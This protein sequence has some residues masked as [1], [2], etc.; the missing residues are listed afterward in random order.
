MITEDIIRVLFRD[1]QATAAIE[2]WLECRKGKRIEP[3]CIRFNRELAQTALINR[4][5][6]YSVDDAEYAFKYAQKVRLEPDM[7]GLKDFGVFGLLAH[8]PRD[9]LTTDVHNDCLC[10]SDQLLN[11]RKLAHPIGPIIFVAAFLAH[12]DIVHPFNRKTFSQSPIVRSDN[13]DLQIVLNRGMAENHFHIGGSTDASI[14]QWICLM[15]HISGNRRAEFLKMK[16]KTQPLDSHPADESLFP[17]VVKAAFIR[18][19]LYCKLQGMVAFMPDVTWDDSQIARYMK[20]PVDKLQGMSVFERN[21][22]WDNCQITWF[23]DMPF[24][25]CELYTRDLD[26]YTYSLRALCPKEEDAN[27]FVSDYALYGEPAPPL[28]DSDLFHIRGRAVRNYE[29]RLYFPIAGEQR[30]LYY[31]FQAIYKKDPAITPYLDLAY[32]YVLIYCKFRA[33]LVQVNERV[34]FKNFLQYQDRKEYFTENHGEYD[35]LRCEIA[36][37]VVTVN[38][39]TAAFEGRMIPS[40]TAE[41]LREKVRRMLTFAAQTE[42]SSPYVQSLLAPHS[43]DFSES[44]NNLEYEKLILLQNRFNIPA[45][46]ELTLNTLKS[47][48]KKLS[49]VLHFAKIAQPILDADDCSPGVAELF[50]LT[51]PRDSQLRQRVKQQSDAIISA[52]AKYPH[53]M[54][55]ITGIDACSSEIDCRPEVFAPQFRRMIQDVPPQK[56]AYEDEYTIP[57][58]RI[59]YHVGEDFLDP[60]DGLRAIDE[61]IEYLDMKPGDRIGHALALGVDCDEWYAFK[62]NTVLLQKQA[63]L[64]NLVWLYGTMLKYNI[65]DTEVETHV[66]KWFK[67]LYKQIFAD[68]L[69]FNKNNHVSILSNIDIEDY[70][71][72]MALRG[73]DPWVYVHNPDGD[74]EERDG[75]ME[76]LR[77]AENEP[78]KLRIKA[79]K[80]YDT[81][82]NTLYHCYHWNYSVKLES[83]RIEEYEVPQCIVR[84]VSLVQKRMRFEIAQ[85]G[86]GIECNPSSNYLIGTFRDYM[87]HPIFKFDNQYLYATSNSA[88]QVPNPH[89]KASINTDDLGIFDTSLE[90]EYALMASALHNHNSHC[91]PEDRI[92]PQQIYAWLDHIRQNGCEQ[93]FKLM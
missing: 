50:E 23:M 31:L 51:H 39:Q 48:N 76:D 64:D 33:E 63:L 47:T 61:A 49:Y 53:V 74:Y 62:G 92:S 29:R 13:D 6:H 81:V 20:I 5:N 70:F 11:F 12:R 1:V 27:G 8:A 84:A 2:R 10:L 93:N 30:F 40:V 35:A 43:E 69:S 15:N 73:N 7:G 58:L 80:G 16:L 75:F 28:D 18:Y 38:P 78:W 25:N 56:S 65:L 37:Q 3:L 52:R 9:M 59:T 85:R 44:I 45:D 22:A 86:I 17:L 14:F 41:K 71:A 66:R 90:N 34:G 83:A 87:K 79:G 46:L 19:F 42:Y 55:W 21:R 26:N 82:S 32:A 24:E 54:S 68:N 77:K 57:P 60:I 88:G 89:I 67:K 72:S 4:I 91:L 36:Q